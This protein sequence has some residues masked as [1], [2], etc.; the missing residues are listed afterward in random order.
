M[1]FRNLNDYD[2]RALDEAHQRVDHDY[3]CSESVS[4]LIDHSFCSPKGSPITVT[5]FSSVLYLTL[6]LMMGPRDDASLGQRL[7][8]SSGF[9][10]LLIT[11]FKG[12]FI[13]C[14]DLRYLDITE[15]MKKFLQLGLR[16]YSLPLM[17]NL[18]EKL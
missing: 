18:D 4:A 11:S 13:G 16:K 1:A 17:D 15:V 6:E 8:Y 12:I 5:P 14:L 7:K 2:P 3:C 9:I 10:F